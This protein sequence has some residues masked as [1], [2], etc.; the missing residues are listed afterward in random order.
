LEADLA[1]S[2][3]RRVLEAELTARLSSLR[4]GPAPRSFVLAF[5][6]YEDYLDWKLSPATGA[7]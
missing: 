6:R 1:L 7:I 4:R 5:D 2:P 3:E